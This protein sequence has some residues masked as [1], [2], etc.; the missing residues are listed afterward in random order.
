MTIPVLVRENFH[1]ATTSFTG[2]RDHRRDEGGDDLV[3]A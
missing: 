2:F 3:V 1:H